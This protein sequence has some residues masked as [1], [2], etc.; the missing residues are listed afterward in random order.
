MAFITPELPRIRK[1]KIIICIL[2]SYIFLFFLK[3]NTHIL[4]THFVMEPFAVA[5]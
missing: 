3:V 2:F 4:K 5:A 1:K